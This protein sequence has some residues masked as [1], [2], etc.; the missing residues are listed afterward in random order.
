MGIGALLFNRDG[1]GYHPS[2]VPAYQKAHAPPK[3]FSEGPTYCQPALEGSQVIFYDPD[4]PREFSM[5][6][7]IQED[8]IAFTFSAFRTMSGMGRLCLERT[9]QKLAYQGENRGSN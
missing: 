1:L 6:P 2:F 9:S 3:R 8:R 7:I 5:I 4:H